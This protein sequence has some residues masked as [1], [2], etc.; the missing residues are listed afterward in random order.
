MKLKQIHS[1][2]G[3]AA[4]IVLIMVAMLT[5]LGLAALNTSDDDVSIAGNVMQE[6]RAFYAAE[7]GLEQ[8]AAMLQ[9]EYDSTGVPPV[10]MPAGS[11]TI[12]NCLVT[13]TSVDNG[14][15]SFRVLTSGTLAGLQALVKSFSLNSTGSSIAHN[16]KVQLAETFEA[17]LVPIFQFAV[18]YDND[19]EIAPGP[20]MTLGGRVHTNGNLW[21][22]SGNSLNI[23]S[24][25]TSA[26]HVFHGRKGPESVDN[27][28]VRIKNGSGTY[29]SMKLGSGWL[30][31]TDSY[32]YDSSVARWQGRVQDSAH[33]QGEL[34]L[35]LTSAASG[36]PHKLIEPAGGN[37]DSYENKATLKFIDRQAFQKV[38]GAWVNVTAT[39]VSQSIITF[40]D[41]K[42]Y[43]GRENTTVDCMELDIGKLYSK[44]YA[45]SNGV[46][47]F[48]DN[49]SDFPALRVKNASTLDAGLT[50]AS[51]NPIYTLG[52]F[53]SVNKKPAALYGDAVTFLS[54]AWNDA[55]S[56]SSVSSRVAAN[57]TVNACYL[58]GNIETTSSNYNGGFENLPRFL[59]K[60]DGK[61]FTWRG[62]AVNLWNSVQADGNWSYGSYYTAPD[63][64]W[65]FDP[66]LNDPNKMPPETPAVRIFQRIGWQQ[67][68]VGYD[69]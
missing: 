13:Y 63:R 7:A 65:A 64:N 40:T 18:F 34:N 10:V 31:S 9:R 4:L 36:D 56:W 14:P 38:G 54:S 66:D 23:D 47:Y 61:T 45:P 3:M 17:D 67:L 49:T 33:G 1:Q 69:E 15:A 22:Q 51:E 39:M 19:L 12:N 25:V 46:L 62:S 27:G 30:E 24:Y 50:I 16:A 11:Q 28:E 59:E 6:T 43:D 8:A 55:N 21:L 41:N 57:T 53:N 58:T 52:N 29:V 44:G 5:L 26:G 20:A 2:R 37:P 32:W 60:W 48:S 35:P 42:F 68:Y